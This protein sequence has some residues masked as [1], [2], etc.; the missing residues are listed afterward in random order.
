MGNWELITEVKDTGY[1]IGWRRRHKMIHMPEPM[2]PMGK[3][4]LVQIGG[5]D[6]NYEVRGLTYA[7]SIFEP[8]GE[9][10]KLFD[11]TYSCKTREE[12]LSKAAELKRHIAKLFDDI[13]RSDN[14]GSLILRV[15]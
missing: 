12:A 8:H 1:Y 13:T 7:H 15:T 2:Q 6:G 5:R 4:S 3:T 9:G 14:I 11:S 10:L